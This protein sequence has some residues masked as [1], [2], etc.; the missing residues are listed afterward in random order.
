MPSN[1]E[2]LHPLYTL[3]SD[4][5]QPWAPAGD[6]RER[7][8]NVTSTLH[9]KLLPTAVTQ[10]VRLW[11]AVLV[12]SDASQ[13]I[14][15]A[16]ECCCGPWLRC[17][18]NGAS[19]THGGQNT[20]ELESAPPPPPRAQNKDKVEPPPLRTHGEWPFGRSTTV[21]HSPGPPAMQPLPPEQERALVPP[22]QDAGGAGSGT[23]PCAFCSDC[24][25]CQRPVCRST[26]RTP[27]A[28]G[29]TEGPRPGGMHKTRCC[30]GANLRR[31]NSRPQSQRPTQASGKSKSFLVGLRSDWPHACFLTTSLWPINHHIFC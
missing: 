15:R 22:A 3:C 25:T 28:G 27:G 12:H 18:M 11:A 13:S 16:T 21:P 17:T 20:H 6:T 8:S 19:L 14:R 31:H 1:S 26:H 5:A 2:R 24:P 10:W 30:R 4:C 7:T 9:P 29:Y 23:L